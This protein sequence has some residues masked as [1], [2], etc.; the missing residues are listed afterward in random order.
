MFGLGP[1]GR[2]IAHSE[3]AADPVAG[4]N[5]LGSDMEELADIA[6]TVSAEYGMS[7]PAVISANLTRLLNRRVPVTSLTAGGALGFANLNFA[8]ATVLLVRGAQT[9]DLGMLAVHA[10]QH[11]VR[12]ESFACT[13]ERVVLTLTSGGGR[14]I[15]VTAVGVAHGG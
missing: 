3:P 4:M 11:Q 14:L 9:G 10:L 5:L 13:V 8:D 1:F 15:D 7:S 6:R 12:L 2:W